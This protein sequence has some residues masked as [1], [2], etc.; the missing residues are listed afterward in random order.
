VNVTRVAAI[1]GQQRS[2]TH[3]L[4][5]ILGSHPAIKYTGEIFCRRV[6]NS[7]EQ[8]HEWVDRVLG[9]GFE[10]VLLDT[11][12]NQISKHV[13]TLLQ[14]NDVKVIELVRENKLRLYFSGVLHT[15]RGQHPNEPKIPTF[16]FMLPQFQEIVAQIERYRE[17]FGYLADVRVYYEALTL[18]R[19]TLVLPSNACWE[20][21]ELLGV[22]PRPL[23]LPES[24]SKEAPTDYLRHLSGVP[25]PVLNRYEHQEG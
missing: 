6:P 22:E 13:E 7:W 9:G 19:N 18:D 23:T 5:A 24:H 10:V 4:G 17:R 1:M 2:G 20:L 8:L 15:W 16:R 12:Y 14:H 11:K 25:R 21:C 3:F